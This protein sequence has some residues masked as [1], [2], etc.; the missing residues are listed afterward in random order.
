MMKR[1][2]MVALVFVVILSL[3]VVACGSDGTESK[4]DAADVAVQENGEEVTTS[5]EE[6]S[7]DEAPAEGGG[8]VYGDVP[9]YPGAQFEGEG[10]A[11]AFTGTRAEGTVEGVS[12]FTTDPLDTVTSWYREQLSGAKEIAGTV[13]GTE[14]QASG[15]VFLM[16]SG[17]GLG[18][19]VTVTSGEGDYGTWITMGEWQGTR[20]KMGD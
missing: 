3:L 11:A 16:L 14:G 17:E 5:S 20:I 15:V 4:T 7:T 13:S 19:A 12:Y 1:A 9:V 10:G 2:L 8:E 18:A 6:S